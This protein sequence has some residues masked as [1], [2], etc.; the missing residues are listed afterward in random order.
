M[1]RDARERRRAAAH[2]S[3]LGTPGAQP[4]RTYDHSTCCTPVSP[5]RSRER[6]GE[7]ELPVGLRA[8]LG[9]SPG[10]APACH[11]TSGR[12]ASR[13]AGSAAPP[14]SWPPR[15][16]LRRPFAGRSPSTRWT[17]PTRR[18]SRLPTAGATG[19]SRAYARSRPT[20]SPRRGSRCR[21]ARA[22]AAPAA[23]SSRPALL[24][25]PARKRPDAGRPRGHLDPQ[26]LLAA[27]APPAPRRLGKRIERV[28]RG[29]PLLDPRR[30][31]RAPRRRRRIG[32][33]RQYGSRLA[34]SAAR[35]RSARPAGRRRATDR[36]RRSRAVAGR[37]SRERPVADD[38]ARTAGGASHIVSWSREAV[39]TPAE[40]AS[41][42]APQAAG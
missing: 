31:H 20:P 28:E 13:R 34:A 42:P 36:T 3:R 6:L 1:D 11:G 7:V 14:R 26:R 27:V 40:R 30:D 32:L 2:C 16:C 12:S 17:R 10:S 18:T 15:S 37:R 21:R 5:R 24:P 25:P 29:R 41:G 33:L 4:T 19:S 35:A 38:L 9:R 22:L 23:A 8:D 39:G